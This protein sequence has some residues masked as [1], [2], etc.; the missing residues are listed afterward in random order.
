MW[1]KNSGRNQRNMRNSDEF[2]IP[3]SR[4][5]CISIFPQFEYQRLWNVICHNNQDLSIEITKKTFKENFK[6]ELFKSVSIICN[7]QRCGE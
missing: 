6:K 4:F 3:I 2:N 7:N 1:K 5:S